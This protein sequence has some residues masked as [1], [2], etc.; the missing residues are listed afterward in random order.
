MNLRATLTAGIGALCTKGTDPTAHDAVNWF[1]SLTMESGTGANQADQA[2]HLAGTLATATALEIDVR[3]GSLVDVFGDALAMVRVKAVYIQNRSAAGL[4]NITGTN[5]IVG[6]GTIG[7]RAGGYF[8]NIAPDATAFPAAAGSTDQITIT[9]PGASGVDYRVIV[10][11]A[12][13]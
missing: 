2:Y 10:I 13:A 5:A 7:V 3:G 6:S 4:L 9:N 8:M 11:G 1:A 12:T